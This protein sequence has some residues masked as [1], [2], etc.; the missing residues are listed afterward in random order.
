M[1]NST[2]S[3]H[4]NAEKLTNAFHIFNQLSENLTLSYQGL[5]QQVAK[6]HKELAFVRSERVKTLIEKEKLAS[7]LQHIL[8]TLPAAVL[9]LDSDGVI[10]DCNAKANEFL[11][12][13]LKSKAWSD[14]LHSRLSPVVDNPH[15]RLL[16]NGKRVSITQS[17]FQDAGQIILLSDISEMRAMQEMLLHQQHLSSMGEMVASLAHQVRTPLSTAMLYASQLTHEEIDRNTQLEFAAKITERL[18][19]L[20][21]QINDMLIFAKQGRMAMESFSLS[22]LLGNIAESMQDCARQ[23]I[24]F[25]INNDCTT[26]RLTGNE[27]ALR[28]AI[29]NLIENAISV[30]PEQGRVQLNFMDAAVDQVLIEVNDNGPGIAP[31]LQQR[32]FEP[33]YTTRISGTGLGLAVVNSVIQAHQGTVNVQSD[34]AS[35]TRFELRLPLNSI[36]FDPLISRHNRMPEQ[37]LTHETV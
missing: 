37:E 3:H 30:A 27:N 16:G 10:L 2:T 26:T 25:E 12:E 17:V 23:D 1:N 5:E 34:K 4:E 19:F 9:V 33:F 6:L 29:M 35:G 14:V 7:R 11:G 22:D 18:Q 32:I 36:R 24:H 8:A 20:E 28:G 21:R 31:E 15:E 13:P